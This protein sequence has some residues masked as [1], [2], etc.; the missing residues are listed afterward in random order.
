MLRI[1]LLTASIGCSPPATTAAGGDAAAVV[2]SAGPTTPT[3][4]VSPPAETTPGTTGPDCT[5]APPRGPFVW[6]R[7]PLQTEE[8]FDFD[9]QGLLLTQRGSDLLGFARDGGFRVVATSIGF[10][11][12]GIR[13]LSTG[14][15]VVAQPDTGSLRFV[16]YGT[17]GSVAILGDLNY[18]NGVEASA[19]GTVYSSE[20]VPNGEIRQLDPATGEVA[21]LATVEW[22]NN[23][24]LSPDE[25]TLYVVSSTG[26]FVGRSTVL[27]LDRDASGA[28]GPEV[29]VFRE[30]DRMLG[31]ITTDA[32]GNVYVVEY[33][34]GLVVRLDP[35]DASGVVLAELPEG[36]SYSSLRFGPGLGD[37]GRT[38]LFATDR[39]EIFVTDVGIEGRHVLAGWPAP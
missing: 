31:G 16:S 11:A 3:P 6:D 13:S 22:P 38:E 28:W 15:L 19:D 26:L 37:Y 10:D 36:G 39:S 24:A 33:A 4:P 25:R 18:P 27:A 29:R 21:I 17:G 32:C 34:G 5:L 2:D 12:A 9:Q 23:L 7:L 8:D 35:D 20:H 14:D 30:Y 1:A